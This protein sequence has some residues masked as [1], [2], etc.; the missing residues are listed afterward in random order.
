MFQYQARAERYEISQALLDCKMAEGSSVSD[1]VIELH[2]YVQRLEALGVPFPAKLGTDRILKSLP[3]SF[4][5]FVM[6]FNIHGMNKTMAKLF[7]MLK[8]AEKDIQKDTNHVMMVKKT[9][10]FKKQRSEP[11]NMGASKGV[12]PSH[13][14]KKPKNPKAGPNADVD[15]FFC[16]E[17]G[18]WKMNY[19]KYLAEKLKKIGTSSLSIFDIHVIHVLLSGPQS[20]YWLFGT[21]SVANICNLIQELWKPRMLEKN[22]V[23]MCI[24]NGAR[25]LVVPVGIMPLHIPSGLN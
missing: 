3:P 24:E 6:N 4:T 10:H 14:P 20:N 15:C 5:S 23:T 9:T 22:E 19:P 1:H 18:H 17:K 2:G 12:G 11:K 8:V 7:T 13:A 16:K 21:G 25:V